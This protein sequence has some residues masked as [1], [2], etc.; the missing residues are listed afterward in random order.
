[1]KKIYVELLLEFEEFKTD[2]LL[3]S[4]SGGENYIGGDGIG[5]GGIGDI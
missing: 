1:M 5:I 3:V 4:G 2:V